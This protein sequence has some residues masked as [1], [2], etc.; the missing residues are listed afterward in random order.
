MSSNQ[1]ESKDDDDDVTCTSVEFVTGNP[2]LVVLSGKLVYFGRHN[3]VEEGRDMELQGQG[4]KQE[5]ECCQGKKKRKKRMLLVS[6]CPVVVILKVYRI[7][8]ST[9]VY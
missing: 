4:E 5:P 8:L 6:C 9:L 2:Q 7:V 3:G 1:R